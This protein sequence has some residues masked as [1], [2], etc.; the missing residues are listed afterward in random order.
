M[1]TEHFP[2]ADIVHL[3]RPVSKKHAPMS[4]YDRAAQFSPFAALTGHGEAIKETA[5]LTENRMNLDEDAKELL[6]EKLQELLTTL[7]KTQTSPYVS[8]TFFVEDTKKEG[9]SYRTISGHF[10]GV[11][12]FDRMLLLDNGAEICLDDICEINSETKLEFTPK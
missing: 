3:K 12:E 8:L 4:L 10:L 11:R 1:S 7:Q 9:G 5:R 2:Y 6:D